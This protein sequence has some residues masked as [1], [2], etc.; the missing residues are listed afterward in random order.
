MQ[1]VVNRFFYWLRADYLEVRRAGQWWAQRM[2]TT[3]RPLEEKLALFWHGHF[4]T[5][6]EKVRDYRKM[7]QQLEL[8]HKHAN[9][10]FRDLLIGVAKDPAMLV[11]L[12]AGENVKGNPNENFGREIL[13]LFTMGVGNYRERDI[14]EAA[15]AFT[16]WTNDSLKDRKSTRLNSSHI[17]KSRMPSSA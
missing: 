6:D 4:A 9:G 17:Q 2:L 8:F 12:D 10:N 14:R 11:Y 3:K 1:P 16:G 5:S 15:R 13:E 7:V